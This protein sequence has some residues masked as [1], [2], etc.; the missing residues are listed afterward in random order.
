MP[1]PVKPQSRARTY[2]ASRRQEQARQTRARVVEVA[3]NRFLDDGYVATTMRSIAADADVSVE[4]VYKSFSNKA[5]LLKA[6]FDIAIAGDDE[7]IPL[8]QRDMVARI[9]AE[10]D[11][12][13]KLAIY[14]EAYAERANRAVPIE[15]L[16]R[17]AA[18]SDAG[19]AEVWRQLNEERFTGMTMFATHLH[20]SGVLRRDVSR[21]DARDVLWLFTAP[22]TFELLVLDRG[23]SLDSFGAWTTQQ[24][25]AALL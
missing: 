4:T 6:M 17:A 23:W 7:P 18:A 12:R 11:G 2:D 9:E 3:R 25:I 10:P 15:L 20:D 21:D 14:G 13:T 8:Q 24:L 1:G 16:A 22:H 5:G 19:A